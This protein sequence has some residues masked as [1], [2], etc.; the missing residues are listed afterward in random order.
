MNRTLIG[1]DKSSVT[2]YVPE[3]ISCIGPSA[4]YGCA[5][6]TSVSAHEPLSIGDSAFYGCTSLKKIYG[7]PESNVPA[8]HLNG[9]IEDKTFYNC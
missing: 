3:Y 1:V 4:F 8:F 2:A 5:S 7:D 9:A 6:L